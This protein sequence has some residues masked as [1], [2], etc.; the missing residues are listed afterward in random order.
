MEAAKKIVTLSFD[1]GEIYDKQL[2]ALLRKYHL[3]ATF[4]L[5]SGFDGDTGTCGDGRVYHK[6]KLEDVQETYAGFEIGSHSYLHRGVLNTAKGEIIENIRKDI[7]LFSNYTSR[8][9]QCFAYPGGDVDNAA[10]EVLFKFESIRFA[11]TI[12]VPD[13]IFAPPQSPYICTPTAH[14]FDP[15]MEQIISEFEAAPNDG[16]QIL[17][18]FG[19]SYEIVWQ[20][21]NGWQRIERLFQRLAALDAAFLCNADAYD[22]AFNR[23]LKM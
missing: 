20:Q 5:C 21:P 13:Y 19:H 8:P 11:R 3:Q 16:I 18:I 2:A 15:N 17:H 9:I 23:F 22:A 10:I 14:M 4:Y 1:D 6:M 7:D 12:P